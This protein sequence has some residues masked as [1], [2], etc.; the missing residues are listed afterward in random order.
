MKTKKL[1][2]VFILLLFLAP[3][4]LAEDQKKEISVDEALKYYCH[5]WIN[6]AYYENPNGTGIKKMNKDGTWEWYSNETIDYPSWSGTFKIVKS[7]I[8]KEGNVY[9]NLDLYAMGYNHPSLAKISDDGNTLEQMYSYT[10]PTEIDPEHKK[11]FR[12]YKK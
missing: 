10:Y 1:F 8:D 6:P 2:Y 12:M 7:W 9:I 5:T 3:V 11:Y 4:L